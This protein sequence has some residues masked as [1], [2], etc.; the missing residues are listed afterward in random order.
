MLAKAHAGRRRW[1][2]N[3]FVVWLA[4]IIYFVYVVLGGVSH[5]VGAEPFSKYASLRG[6]PVD[7]TRSPERQLHEH[8]FTGKKDTCLSDVV[9]RMKK[10]Q[11]ATFGKRVYREFFFPAFLRPDSAR[12]TLSIQPRARSPSHGPRAPGSPACLS[13]HGRYH[14][15]YRSHVLCAGVWLLTGAPP[16][17]DTH[18]TLAL[19]LWDPSQESTTCETRP[20]PSARTATGW[21]GTGPACT[22]SRVISIC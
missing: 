9:E 15:T 13:W 6:F 12:P 19:T 10:G 8:V 7:L 1:I 4:T 17:A 20:P 22:G 16:V 14:D 3:G 11:F 18:D 5:K 2:R 21:S